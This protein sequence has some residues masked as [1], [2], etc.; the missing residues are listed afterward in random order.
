[1]NRIVNIACAVPVSIYLLDQIASARVR[2]AVT[3]IRTC[4]IIIIVSAAGLRVLFLNESSHPIVVINSLL[5]GAKLVL[6][7]SHGIGNRTVVGISSQVAMS[8]SI[9]RRITVAITRQAACDFTHRFYSAQAVIFDLTAAA[10]ACDK[11]I[12]TGIRIRRD[13]TAPIR[14]RFCSA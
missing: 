12:V 8:S 6:G 2:A 10:W 11:N 1:M 3:R 14:D 4:F 7:H 9:L 5:R 13:P